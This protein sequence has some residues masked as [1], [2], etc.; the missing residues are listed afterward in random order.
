MYGG[1]KESGQLV[2]RVQ[3]ESEMEVGDIA[4]STGCHESLRCQA[5]DGSEMTLSAK[6]DP[7]SGELVWIMETSEEEVEKRVLSTNQ[8]TSMLH[9]T[10]RNNVYEKAIEKNIAHFQKLTGRAPVVLDVGAGTGLLSMMAKRSGAEQVVGCEMFDTMASVATQVVADNNMSDHVQIIAAKS[11]DIGGFQADMLVS[12][13]LDSALLG[14]GCAFSHSDAIERLLVQEDGQ[15]MVVP[16]SQRV[17]PHS[18][19]IFGRLV[20]CSELDRMHSVESLRFGSASGK[21]TP[22]RNEEAPSCRGGW[23]AIP[24]H[25]PRLKERCNAVELS[26]EVS[27]LAFEFWRTGV[28]DQQIESTLKEIAVSE[29]GE[30]SGLL[31]YWQL[32]LLSPEVDPGRECFYTT[33]PSEKEGEAGQWQD[34]W[35]Q[36]VFPFSKPMSVKKGDIIAVTS[37]HNN[38]NI[39]FDAEVLGERRSGSRTGGSSSDPGAAVSMDVEGNDPVSAPSQCTCGWHLL[40][41]IDRLLM[42]NDKRRALLFELEVAKSMKTVCSSSLTPARNERAIVLDV[43]DASVLG[44]TA[45]HYLQ[46]ELQKQ[47]QRTGQVLVV[48]K[49][50]KLLSRLFYDRLG[51][52]NDLDDVFYCWDGED[53]GEVLSF[54]DDEGE[55]EGEQKQL[56]IAALISD[57]YHFQMSAKPIWQMLAFHYKR[58]VVSPLLLPG[59]PIV[60]ARAQVMAAAFELTDLYVS[61]GVNGVVSGFSHKHLDERQSDWQKYWL[62][63]KLADYRKKLLCEPVALHNVDFTR[64]MVSL[65]KTTVQMPINHSGRLDCLAVWV[66]YGLGAEI[67]T[68]PGDST[69]TQQ[70]RF[71]RSYSKGNYPVPSYVDFPPHMKVTLRFF[72]YSQ[73]RAVDA[74]SGGTVRVTSSFEV[75]ASDFNIEFTAS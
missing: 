31:L 34:H 64:D 66:D 46:E 54:F 55:G 63:Y 70:Q 12:E 60:P 21:G 73:Q 2:G 44:I 1:S 50:S 45:G 3:D 28:S 71:M 19:K 49:E 56:R 38:M 62:P 57:M 20:Q 75:G 43:G 48:S 6:L 17:I 42:V 11:T 59:A 5:E 40:H 51:G 30:V 36:C 53:F 4:D 69:Q 72:P 16:I 41:S 15:E 35:V 67:R 13:L 52:N 61:H 58:T 37:C 10:V 25:W 23:P 68:Q 22:W 47:K 14:E 33:R 32:D 27:L 29:T 24:A 7:S 74:A 26:D 8:M 65:P 9:D 39:W 18:A